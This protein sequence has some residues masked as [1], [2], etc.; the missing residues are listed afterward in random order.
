MTA[1]FGLKTFGA[2]GGGALRSQGLPPAMYPGAVASDAH[3]TIAVD[4]LQTRLAV[5]LSAS[6]TAMTVQNGAGIIPNTL[7]TIDNEIVQTQ[8]GAGQQWQII[9]GRDGTTP[10]THLASAIVSGF[11]DA[12][13]HNALVSEIQA[14]QNTLGPNLSKIP[15]SNEVFSSTYDFAPQSPGGSL[16]IGNNVITL[17]PV[18]LGVNGSNTDHYLYVSGGTGTPEKVLITGGSAVS[19][20]ATGTLF[21]QCANPHSGAW[22]IQSA[23]SG[24]QEAAWA[25]PPFQRA[26][27]ILPASNTIFLYATVKAVPNTAISIEGQA[28]TVS[29]VRR[30]ASFP[31][32]DLFLYDQANLAGGF[33]MN[34]LTIV[35]DSQGANNPGG[36]AIHIRNQTNNPSLIAN[37]VVENGFIGIL[38]NNSARVTIDSF[39][40]FQTNAY[41]TLPGVTRSAAGIWILG[42]SGENIISNSRILAHTADNALITEWGLRIYGS[43]GLQVSATHIKAKIGIGLTGGNNGHLTNLFFNNMV[44]D[45]CTEKG[46]EYNG[47]N[48]G[49]GIGN[50]LLASSQIVS[51][52]STIT[53]NNLM[54]IDL[55]DLDGGPFVFAD[56]IIAGWKGTGIRLFYTGSAYSVNIHGGAIKDCGV[57]A[58]HGYGIQA[59]GGSGGW[60]VDGVDIGGFTNTN[61]M[62]YAIFA[63]GAHDAIRIVSNRLNQALLAP[64][65]LSGAN[66]NA[67]IRDNIGLDDVIASVPSAA[68]IALPLNPIFLVTGTAGVSTVTSF[69]PA[70]SRG[71]LRTPNAAITFTAGASIGN[72]FTTV[73]NVPVSWY[74]DGTRIWIG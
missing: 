10:A 32:G 21:I 31:T 70:G 39:T 14:I 47:P 23:T 63:D 68:T 18:P 49:Y 17:T 42:N 58:A 66:T 40:F 34:G 33:Y 65:L 20:A 37:I 60:S 62:D 16:T 28:P 55:I 30:H 11:I 29:V 73:Q 19:G 71:L 59:L 38:L 4:R 64:V 44:L 54:G 72:T 56:N 27:V 67:V 8:A 35:N 3:L 61:S 25:I 57:P 50:I 51:Y 48:T 6:D 41:A 12:W 45:V 15:A 5:P 2:N 43:D 9:R 53:P 26:R 46:F 52:A 22:Q 74:W 69:M 24:I 7:L 13:H 36:A 1:N